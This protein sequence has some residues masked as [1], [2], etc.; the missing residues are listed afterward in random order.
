MPTEKS[1]DLRRM[2]RGSEERRRCGNCHEAHQQHAA[3][4][5]ILV[6]EKDRDDNDGPELAD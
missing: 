3:D 5:R 1:N 4:D 2:D 6:R